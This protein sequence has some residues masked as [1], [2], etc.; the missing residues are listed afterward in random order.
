MKSRV[1]SGI[2]TVGAEAARG[3]PRHRLAAVRYSQDL[4]PADTR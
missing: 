3:W 4:V 1:Q 2:G